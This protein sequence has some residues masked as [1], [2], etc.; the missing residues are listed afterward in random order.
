MEVAI[1]EHG[2]DLDVLAEA[3]KENQQKNV[4]T[5]T[6]GTHLSHTPKHCQ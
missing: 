3:A 6:K 2:I 5:S 4:L 1:G